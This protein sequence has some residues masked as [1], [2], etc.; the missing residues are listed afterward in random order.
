MHTFCFVTRI[1][2]LLRGL[3]TSLMHSAYRPAYTLMVNTSRLLY[4]FVL[5]PLN[6]FE[7]QQ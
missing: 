2:G 6:F 4:T 1:I 5:A 3:Y 7:V